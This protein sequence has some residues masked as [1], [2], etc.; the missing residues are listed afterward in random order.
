MLAKLIDRICTIFGIPVSQVY[1]WCDST[2]VLSW[3]D[4]RPRKLERY[5]ANRVK[6]ITDLLHLCTWKYVPTGD[7]PADCASRRVLPK[8]LVH[9]SLW[10]HGPT[11]LAQEPSTWPLLPR[12]TAPEEQIVVCMPLTAYSDLLERY[13]TLQRTEQVLAWILRFYHNVK[14]MNTVKFLTPLQLDEL[15]QAHK[16]LVKYSQQSYFHEELSDHLQA[17][18]SVSTHS[19]LIMLRPVVDSEGILRVGGRLQQS[20]LKSS[21]THPIILHG[22]SRLSHLIL[23]DIHQNLLHA[24]PQQMTADASQQYHIMSCRTL[25]Q[26]VYRS[27]VPCRRKQAK[28][29]NQLMGQL[30]TYRFVTGHPFLHTGIDYAGPITIKLGRVRTPVYVKAYICVFVSLSVKAVHL[31]L[32]SDQ[33]TDAFIAALRRFVARRGKPARLHSDHGSIFLGANRKLREVTSHLL[34]E[35]SSHEISDFCGTQ[36]I[37]WSF[38]PEKSPNFGG[39]WE[40]TVKSVKRHLH[41]CTKD[42]PFTFDELSTLLAQIEAVLNS[43][44]LVPL[45]SDDSD[46]MALTPGHFL[47]GQP[48][49]AV[50]KS[51]YSDLK[52]L[53]R[54]NLVQKITHDFW[55]RWSKE[56]IFTLNKLNKWRKPT[57][58]FAEG[59]VVLVKRESTFCG[60]WPMGRIIKVYPGNDGKVRVADVRVGKSTYRRTVSKLVILLQESTEAS[61]KDAASGGGVWTRL[62]QI[63][64]PRCLCVCFLMFTSLLFP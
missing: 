42:H 64:E 36:G 14:K 54:W 53:W 60:K 47:I 31:E 10:W 4:G 40:A 26:S 44:P 18:N 45:S 2:T 35:A 25:A 38:I 16:S 32:V 59:D 63:T 7:T 55:Q 11:W 19:P 12:A 27:C 57:Y 20:H 28:S 39:L 52:L 51:D 49:T 50:P 9:H 8:N 34:R 62:P 24:G 23:K 58:N 1:T 41:I 6:K 37:E 30:P 43:S 61:P 56:Y 22:S 5:V 21:Q 13:S 46:A 48:L 29:V 15:K 3:L 33:T 17:G